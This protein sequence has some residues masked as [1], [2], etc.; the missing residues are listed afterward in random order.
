MST[1]AEAASA[2]LVVAWGWLGPAPHC[3]RRR[4][5]LTAHKVCKQDNAETDM[6]SYALREV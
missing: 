5:L 4:H 1:G 2:S 3:H 6:K